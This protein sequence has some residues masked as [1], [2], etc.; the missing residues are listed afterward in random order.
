MR[1]TTL[2]G[3]SETVVPGLATSIPDNPVQVSPDAIERRGHHSSIAQ[4]FGEQFWTLFKNNLSD[5]ERLLGM[6]LFDPLREALTE[7]GLI[8]ELWEMH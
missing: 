4:G 6:S 1:G 7:V 2:F 8:N 5:P 3:T